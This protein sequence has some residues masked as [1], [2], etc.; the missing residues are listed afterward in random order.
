MRSDLK[1]VLRA[2]LLAVGTLLITPDLP[3]AAQSVESLGAERF[4]GSYSLDGTR[5]TRLCLEVDSADALPR[6]FGVSYDSLGR[7]TTIYRLYFGNLDSRA[8]WTI[9]RFSYQETSSGGL[10]TSR[11][12]HAP[13]GTPVIIGVAYGEQTLHDSTGMLRMI[14]QVDAD[15]NRVERVN[16]VTAQIFRLAPDG[17]ILQEWRYSNNKQFH[18]GES[19]YWNMQTGP[20]S[21]DA[22]FRHLV[23]DERGD[24]TSEYPMAL[25]MT[26]IPFSDGSEVRFYTRNKCGMPT[27]VEHRR[28]DSS[29]MEN[30]QGVARI[31]FE[32]N[33]EGQMTRWSS[34]DLEDEPT[35]MRGDAVSGV[36]EYR[37]FDG[38]FVRES[39][40]NR[41]GELI[42]EKE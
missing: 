26:P 22:Y 34:Y 25:T 21:E 4:F 18:G 3:M 14:V 6:S 15:G 29:L 42:S 28:H 1:S 33:E 10:I 8:D 41:D 2:L 31:R 32:Y 7:P 30:R 20:L 17:G 23:I 27:L 5:R 40:Y 19:D 11:T 16:A 24:V 39:L 35:P 13:N 9:M 38:K 36:R 37:P 12:W